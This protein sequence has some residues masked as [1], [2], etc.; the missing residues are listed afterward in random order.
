[1]GCPPLVA[2]PDD[3]P[4]EP[5]EMLPGIGLFTAD[6]ILVTGGTGVVATG[7]GAATVAAIAGGAGS[8]VG[9]G[10]SVG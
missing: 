7:E 1:M 10:A 2:G 9:G 4:V 6:G 3:G 8:A 5:V